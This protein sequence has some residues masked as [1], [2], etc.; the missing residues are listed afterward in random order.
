MHTP[1]AMLLS[2]LE[3]GRA[4]TVDSL[5]AEDSGTLDA[6][7]LGRLEELGFIRGE[8]VMVLRRGPGGGAPIAVQ[9]GEAV[10]A[11]RRVEADCVWVTDAIANDASGAGS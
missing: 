11:L 5:R 4:A 10:F 6:G 3:A 1:P 8:P 7:A 2:R 9:I